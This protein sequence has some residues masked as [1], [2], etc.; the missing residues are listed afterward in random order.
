MHPGDSE[1]PV[2]LI[3]LRVRRPDRGSPCRNS[4]ATAGQQVQDHGNL[5]VTCMNVR[6]WMVVDKNGKQDPIEPQR[7]HSSSYAGTRSR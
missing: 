6:R 2:S 4:N 3:L 5:R 7:T 1:H